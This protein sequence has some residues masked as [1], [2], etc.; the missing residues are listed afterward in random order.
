M[1]L[2]IC[3]FLIA[4][5]WA[6]AG[7]AGPLSGSVL[8]GESLEPI[9]DAT[10]TVDGTELRTTSN[11]VGRYRF[12]DVPPGLVLVHVSADGYAPTVEEIELTEQGISD[13]VIVL[14]RPDTAS[15]TIEVIGKAPLIVTA[16]GQTKLAREELV[17]LPGTRGDA[18][19]VIKSLPG[20]ANADAAGSGP[21]LLVIRGAAPEDSLFLLDGVQIP[22]VY[23]FFGLQSVLPSEFIDDI[24][25][26]PGGFG[27]EQGRAT[28][29]IVHIRTRPNRALKWNG[30]TEMSFINVAGYLQGPLWKSQ[31]V[32]V[33]AAF[34][35]S[36]IDFI[37]PLVIPDSANISFTTAPQ[38]YD[39]QV[40][41]DWL[42]KEHHRVTF[43]NLISYDLLKL[44]SEN[45]NPNDPQASGTFFNETAF[46]R[47]MATWQYKSKHLESTA[48]A[49][50]GLGDFRIEIGADRFLHGEGLTVQL[51]EDLQWRAFSKL[52]LR[53]GG[54]VQLN[55]GDFAAKF[56]LPPQEGV[57]DMPN[58]TSDPL[59]EIDDHFTD[60][61]GAAWFTG[62]FK[63]VRALTITPGIRYDYYDRINA[64]TVSPRLSSK[65]K[66]SPKWT[67]RLA[68][69]TYTRPLD[70][71]ESLPTHLEPELATQY[72]LGGEY[73]IGGGLQASSSAFYTDRR[74]LV[75]QDPGRVM[76][77]PTDAYVNAGHGQSYGVELMVRAKRDDFFG[78]IAYTLSR[79]TR[80]DGPDREERLFDYDQ[81]HNFIAV[82]SWQWG[83]WTFG[84]RWQLTTGEPTTPVEGSIFLSDINTYVPVFGA[85]NSDR[86]ENAHQLDIRVD[87]KW[88]FASWALE[89]YLD[90]TNV[91][92]H[93]RTLGYQYS[94]DYQER[95]AFETLPIFPAIGVRGSF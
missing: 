81:T 85:Y 32:S 72:V 63:P 76:T 83:A 62:D 60:H 6:S 86:I 51:R 52:T 40:R 64:H 35:R 70:Q 80:V 7:L 1:S 13:R 24:E 42:P 19:Q 39:G 25:F 91:Y 75:V 11:E 74:Q 17:K 48:V 47:T 46:S 55:T 10:L 68:L 66:I 61:R 84:G 73:L 31:N 3:S 45:E 78:W 94:F 67:A 54:D 58:F 15:E 44:L 8:D 92:A 90:I 71:A 30:F 4:L 69:G 16:P 95:T 93:A 22:L 53:A 33:A 87:R 59:L 50:L 29:G 56:P 27:V 77:D 79:G 43:L 88:T 18:M 12:A 21:G 9:A 57:P 28:G 14:L 23:H 89:A 65:Y 26:L 49:S 5:S 38:Y 82:A 2:R 41:V 34:R 20:V 36:T 37:L